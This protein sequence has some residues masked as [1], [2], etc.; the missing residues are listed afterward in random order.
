MTFIIECICARPLDLYSYR[1]VSV[2]HRHKHMENHNHSLK[3]SL[4][5]CRVWPVCH[6]C[7][8]EENSNCTR[9]WMFDVCDL[10]R[11]DSIEDFYFRR[12]FNYIFYIESNIFHVHE[13][14][15]PKRLKFFAVHCFRLIVSC[16][17]SSSSFSNF[18][19]F[20]FVGACHFLVSH[21]WCYNFSIIYIPISWH[22][23]K[24]IFIHINVSAFFGFE[25][26][27]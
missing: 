17:F 21:V 9:N 18:F 10:I 25:T 24:R 22:F 12:L 23:F 1:T 4:P 16:T 11:E 20:L 7:S 15:I 5:L 13:S 27:K 8:F 19:F 3:K 26:K 2:W 14:F 6:V